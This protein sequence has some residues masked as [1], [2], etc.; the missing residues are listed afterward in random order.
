MEIPNDKQQ[1]PMKTVEKYS[2]GQTTQKLDIVAYR[3]HHDKQ[4]EL[5]A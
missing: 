4:K 1:F 2:L 3:I 5:I